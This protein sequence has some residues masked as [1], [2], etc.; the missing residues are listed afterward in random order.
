MPAEFHTVETHTPTHRQVYLELCGCVAASAGGLKKIT[1]PQIPRFSSDS[2]SEVA[3]EPS[4][5]RL[6]NVFEDW[7]DGSVSTRSP[8]GENMSSDLPVPHKG[9]HT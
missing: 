5:K 9:G 2:T 1:W 4:E 3:D 7:E 8:G 6:E